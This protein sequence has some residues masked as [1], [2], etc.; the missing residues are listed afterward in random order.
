MSL[1]IVTLSS[2][3][4]KPSPK[5]LWGCTSLNV[6]LILSVSV[7]ISIWNELREQLIALEWPQLALRVVIF[8]LRGPA[9][10]L[11]RAVWL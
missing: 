10:K 5:V 3:G 7:A 9:R 8:Y 6:N 2:F 11:F 4:E 1:P